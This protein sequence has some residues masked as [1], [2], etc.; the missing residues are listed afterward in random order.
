LPRGGHE[1]RKQR[2]R[3]AFM[4]RMRDKASDW[5]WAKSQ[6]ARAKEKAAK[7][8]RKAARLRRALPSRK[9]ARRPPCSRKETREERTAR[10]TTW[11]AGVD[12]DKADVEAL[13]ATLA[14]R[15]K[16]KRARVQ[17]EKTARKVER[18]RAFVVREAKREA[19][20]EATRA[21]ERAAQ[22]TK[23]VVGVLCEPL[24]T[25][26]EFLVSATRCVVTAVVAAGKAV[27]LVA[28]MAKQPSMSVSG[29]CSVRS[30]VLQRPSQNRANKA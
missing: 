10:L 4:Q 6:A 25:V 14:M 5:R 21:A 22:A 15:A 9:K 24:R 30:S 16:A 19:K 8:A 17:R 7:E 13:L 11:A 3:I 12:R 20:R 28:S 1:G 26:G 18:E 2:K 27:A 29:F 23:N